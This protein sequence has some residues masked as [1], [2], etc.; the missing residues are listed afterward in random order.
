M[1]VNT[2]WG[3][4]YHVAREALHMATVEASDSDVNGV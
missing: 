4:G 1:V 3:G 2:E